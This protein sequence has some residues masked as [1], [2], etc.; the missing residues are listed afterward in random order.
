MDPA[1]PLGQGPLIAPVKDQGAGGLKILEIHRSTKRGRA[2]MKIATVQQASPDQSQ[3]EHLI[4]QIV[5]S[6]R[7]VLSC[8]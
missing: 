1:S 6:V 4:N 3:E 2:E 5:P 8:R 7:S